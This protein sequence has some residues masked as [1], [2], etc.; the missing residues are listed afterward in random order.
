MGR[1]PSA[2]LRMCYK[3]GKN[4]TAQ[5]DS[6]TETTHLCLCR[7][8]TQTCPTCSETGDW[9]RSPSA[10]AASEWRTAR[11]SRWGNWAWRRR[12][13]GRRRRR[14]ACS[15]T[16]YRRS[17]R[18]R[19][20]LWRT[21]N[22]LWT[23]REEGAGISSFIKTP[24]TQL[25]RGVLNKRDGENNHIICRQDKQSCKT[26]WDVVVMWVMEMKKKSFSMCRFVLTALV[27][28]EI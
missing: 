26:E 9:G 24:S 14:S 16:S 22:K 15:W 1:P 27:W 4:I 18:W 3:P 5:P 13:G 12:C 2:P 7:T 25:I 6:I 23:E 10:A 19:T 11:L 17:R 28:V 8:G 21:A 20:H